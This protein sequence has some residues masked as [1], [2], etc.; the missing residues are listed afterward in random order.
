MDFFNRTDSESGRQSGAI[1]NKLTEDL[2][3]GDDQISNLKESDHHSVEVFVS[4][5]STT[6]EGLIEVIKEENIPKITSK[7]NLKDL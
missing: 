3:G 6:E 4:E 2:G 7:I 1:K 5:H